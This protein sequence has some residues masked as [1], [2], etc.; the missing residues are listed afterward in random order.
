MA[1][2][3]ASLDSVYLIAGALER[4]RMPYA[5]IGGVAL[6][7]W[8]VPR[9]TFDLDLAVSVPTGRDGELLAELRRLGVV[10]DDA[11]EGGFRDRVQGMEKLHVHL[12]AGASLMAIDLFVAGTPFL[13]SVLERRVEFDLG[14]GRLWVCS[15]ADL[16]VLKLLADRRKDRFDVENVLLVQ[17]V[18]EPEYLRHWA[19][20]LGIEERLTRALEQRRTS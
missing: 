8:G 6:N 1:D 7:T 3:P 4:V 11:F 17:G 13:E 15:A 9:A 5:F 12:P 20:T 19:A 18:P 10:V 16:V 14:R 2:V